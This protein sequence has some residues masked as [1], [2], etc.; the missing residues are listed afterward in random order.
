MT[1]E[2]FKEGT[3]RGLSSLLRKAA[4]EHANDHMDR[5][6]GDGAYR[7]RQQPR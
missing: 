6:R 3:E 7:G 4:L 5:A 1:L 2:E